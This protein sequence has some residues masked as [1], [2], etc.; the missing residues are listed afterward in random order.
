MPRPAAG[1]GRKSLKSP[2]NRH[3]RPPTRRG[4]PPQLRLDF[5]ELRQKNTPTCAASPVFARQQKR[6]HAS[7]TKS[8]R[9][10]PLN[11]W[12]HW[13]AVVTSG[14][15]SFCKHR[16]SNPLTIILPCSLQKMTWTEHLV[17]LQ[18]QTQKPSPLSAVSM[19]APPA[20]PTEAR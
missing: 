3:H 9:R 10:E 18:R 12:A 15:G 1:L 14:S 7:P 5:K 2:Q 11:R 20:W 19:P 8:M 13:R 4:H 17:L 16:T 6:I